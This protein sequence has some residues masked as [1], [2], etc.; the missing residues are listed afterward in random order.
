M[1][2][3]EYWSKNILDKKIKKQLNNLTEK[4][5]Q[6]NF[7]ANLEFGTAGMR[8]VMQ[9]GTL[10]MN[11]LTVCK[12]AY[13]TANYL[14]NF[15]KKSAVICFDTRNN[16]KKFS[17]LFAKVLLAFNV[18]VY[19]FEDYA[20]TPLCVY[21]TTKLNATIGVMITA[22]HNNKTF[23]GIKIYDSNG[24]QIND[25]TQQAISKVFNELN[26]VDVYNQI[27]KQKVV[28]KPAYIS[29]KQALEFVDEI[30]DE[31][32]KQLNV[33]YTP[34]NGTGMKYVDKILTQN[35]YKYFV[36]NCQKKREWRI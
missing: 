11:E 7:A 27:Y 32:K 6:D 9:V 14:Q 17:R 21:M 5:I 1:N 22:S 20:P 25:E 3:F 2:N 31:H 30:K 15:G 16:S 28:K 10:G 4:Q 18:D 29:T 8:G 34:L 33:I 36:P 23:N 13:A 35:G 26:E 19:L 12:L 24:I